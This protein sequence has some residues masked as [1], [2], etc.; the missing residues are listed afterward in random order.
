MPAI[1]AFLKEVNMKTKGYTSKLKTVMNE[2]NA[3]LEEN[4][5]FRF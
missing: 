2:I 4:K 3:L 1:K 5:S